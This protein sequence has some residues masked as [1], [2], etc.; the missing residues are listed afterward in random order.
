MT[1]TRI[2]AVIAALAVGL[3]GSAATAST[4]PHHHRPLSVKA[5]AYKLAKQHGW[6]NQWWAINEIVSAESG[7]NPCAV[8]PGRRLCYYT[9]SSSCGIPQAQPCPWRNLWRTRY[10][11]V[12][13]F[14][15]YIEHHIDSDT[16]RP[17]GTPVG[18]LAFR[19]VHNWY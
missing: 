10:A 11:Q 1:I 15:H 9:G 8:N 4:K 16:G 12:R 2:A 6:A 5:Y 17:Y 7:W 14:F 3:S 19:R 18:A 13:W